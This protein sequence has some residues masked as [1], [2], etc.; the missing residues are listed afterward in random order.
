MGKFIELQNNDVIKYEAL[1]DKPFN[2]VFELQGILKFYKFQFFGSVKSSEIFYDTPNNLLYKAGIVISRVQEGD[3]VFFKVAP[4][5]SF[6][7]IKTNTKKIFSHKVGV[8][9][10]LKDHSFYLVDGVKGLFSTPLYI[11]VEN[12]IKN[13]KPK[14]AVYINANIYKIISGTGFRSFMCHEEIKYENF[15]SKRHTTSKGMTLKFI[16]S[17][18]YLKEFNSFNDSIKK[19]CKEF[20]E[21]H[22]N[23]YEHASKITKKLDKKQVKLDKK[24][25]KEN[26]ANK[27]LEE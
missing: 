25:A 18:H 17:E 7:K 26:I 20:I 22:D 6:S 24:K 10:T 4:S 3:Q 27:K 12:V 23:L 15:E 11:D 19:Y 5:A 21:I 9:D 13:A 8:K 1:T 16:G 14:V 2:K